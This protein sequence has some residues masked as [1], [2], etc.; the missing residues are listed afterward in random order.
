MERDDAQQQTAAAKQETED[1]MDANQIMITFSGTQTDAI[2]RL[3]VL[4][5]GLGGDPSTIQA[6][7][8]NIY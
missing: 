5:T 1:Q 7:G 2:D 4:A 8:G 3:K 6:A